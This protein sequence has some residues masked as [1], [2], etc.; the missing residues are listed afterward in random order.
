MK[1]LKNIEEYDKA[2]KIAYN[3]TC[4][5]LHELELK[6]VDIIV[7]NI[8]RHP[9]D[10]EWFEYLRINIYT[11]LTSHAI[12]VSYPCLNSKEFKN[13]LKKAIKKQGKG[14]IW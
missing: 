14:Q 11:P 2:I 7:E 1:E 13:V 4:E 9:S 10:N 12:T 6:Y 3:T 5:I 8:I